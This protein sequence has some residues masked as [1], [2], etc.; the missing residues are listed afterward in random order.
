MATMPCVERL[1]TSEG[2]PAP[3]VDEEEGDDDDVV[4]SAAMGWVVV[5]TLADL[6][7]ADATELVAEGAE[8]EDGAVAAVP[9]DAVIAVAVLNEVVD[10]ALLLLLADD[11]AVVVVTWWLSCLRV[12]EVEGHKVH[13]YVVGGHPGS[14]SPEYPSLLLLS[15]H[16]HQNLYTHKNGV[17]V[18]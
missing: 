2:V 8:D 18:K 5:V 10:C 16:Q 6:S 9:V 14:F 11:V 17:A 3:I 15:H 1:P 12:S 7:V 4:E 13:W